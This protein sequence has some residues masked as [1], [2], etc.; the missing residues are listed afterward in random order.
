VQVFDAE[1][2]EKVPLDEAQKRKLIN[3]EEGVFIQSTTGDK[4]P[5]FDAIQEGWVM[6][7]YTTNEP[8]QYQKITYAVTYVVDQK[9]KRKVPFHEAVDK[10]LIDKDTGLLITQHYAFV[11]LV[12]LRKCVNKQAQTLFFRSS[13][14]TYFRCLHRQ[15]LP[16]RQ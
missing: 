16:Q 2:G 1:R 3:V 4:V 15:L 9:E 7:T 8:A 12:N 10:G 14:C 5:L 11:T 6:A 13:F